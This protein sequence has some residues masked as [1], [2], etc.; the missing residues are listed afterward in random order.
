M[1]FSWAP[2]IAHLCSR[3]VLR[4]VKERL[5]FLWRYASVYIDNLVIF[6]TDAAQCA[7]AARVV[8][9]VCDEFG[10]HIKPDSL[11][12]G[13][14]C[15]WRGLSIDLQRRTSTFS[16]RF[17]RKITETAALLSEEVLPVRVW[18]CAL[19]VTIYMLHAQDRALSEM[20][21]SMQFFA[22]AAR[23]IVSWDDRISV[24][25][26]VRAQFRA[27]LA[28]AGDPTVAPVPFPQQGG[29]I[30]LA[31]AAGSEEFGACAAL[32]RV[33]DAFIVTVWDP[34]QDE[35]IVDREFAACASPT[36]RFVPAGCPVAW[37]SDAK[38]AVAWL[39]DLAGWSR[40][41]KRNAL[42][43]SLFRHVRPASILAEHIPGVKNKV[44]MLT[45][46]DFGA[47]GTWTRPA[48]EHIPSICPCAYAFLEEVYRTNA[49]H[50]KPS[51]T[52]SDAQVL[53][54]PVV[55]DGP[56]FD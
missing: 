50:P 15:E 52:I 12:Q 8:S 29:Y 38:V 37:Y 46:S 3:A 4:A 34:L 54:W 40:L 31:D 53:A 39:N 28:G 42:R 45:R 11:T 49:A 47:R 1:G 35:H 32:L 55:C 23:R 7:H 27:I 22:E 10:A 20:A 16:D 25:T 17:C 13:T 41:S 6:V 2:L 18:W 30:G 9:Q 24:P 5:P 26:A 33:P 36:L 48:C 44:D 14:S 43:L 56:D 21:L 19:G 51:L